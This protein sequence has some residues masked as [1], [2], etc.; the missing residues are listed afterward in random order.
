M[1]DTISIFEPIYNDGGDTIYL[2][3]QIEGKKSNMY[4]IDERVALKLA[5]NKLKDKEKYI[6]SERYMFGKT[7]IE[8]ASEIGISQAQISRIEKSALKNIKND[9]N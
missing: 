4:N 7:Q 9:M 8:L 6:I 5:I 2:E 1:K 3:D